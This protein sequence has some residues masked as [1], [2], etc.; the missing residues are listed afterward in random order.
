M[1]AQTILIDTLVDELHKTQLAIQRIQSFYEEFK[2]KDMA[3]LGRTRT[4][5]V[6]MAEIFV[7]FY[8]CLETLFLKTS[9]FFENNL[10]PHRWHT[11]LL[12]KMTLE[13]QSVR[14]AVLSEHTHAL[15][16]ELMKFRHFKRHY[17]EFEYDWDKLDYL[18]KKYLQVIPCFS[19]DIKEFE[20]FLLRLNEMTG[21]VVSSATPLESSLPMPQHNFL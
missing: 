6:V 1:T 9:Q 2:T 10:P 3:I 8:T 5:A 14:K 21:L 4:T 18:E 15:L 11:E 19:Q 7:D 12:H 17:F 20:S 16:F 13:I